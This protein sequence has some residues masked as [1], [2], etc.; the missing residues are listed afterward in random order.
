MRDEKKV[1]EK[2]HLSE[3]CCP[4]KRSDSDQLHSAR[5]PGHDDC[6]VHRPQTSRA[7]LSK[8]QVYHFRPVYLHR[9]TIVTVLC[10]SLPPCT[11]GWFDLSSREPLSVLQVSTLQLTLVAARRCNLFLVDSL[12]HLI[13]TVPKKFLASCHYSIY[14]II[15]ASKP[16]SR[17]NCSNYTHGLV[18]IRITRKSL[19]FSF[20]Q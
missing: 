13:S 17:N 15:R 7:R 4:S 20:T 14:N 9:R 18:D 6:R 12:I 11:A 16:S 8:N 5:G 1:V 19:F 3:E 10:S 2:F